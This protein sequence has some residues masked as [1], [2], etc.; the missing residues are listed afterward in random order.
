M[1]FKIKK[2]VLALLIGAAALMIFPAAGGAL[3]AAGG[4]PA[5]DR[6]AGYLL[7]QEVLPGR[8]L[9]PWSYAA[10]GGCGYDLAGTGVGQS[11]AQQFEGLQSGELNNYSLLVLTLLAAGD[12]PYDYRGQD[13]VERIRAAQLPDGKFADKVDGGGLGAGGEQVLANAH[14]WA[15]LA[16]H[17]AGA[18]VPDARKAGE[19]LC[20]RQRD[21]GSFNWNLAGRTPDVDSTGMALLALG[22]LGEKEGPVVQK[23]VA[24]LKSVQEEDGGFSSWGAANAESCCMV[25]SGLAAV[26]I[27]P[28]GADWTAPAGSPVTA[29]QSYRLPDGSY[30]HIKGAGSNVMATEQALQAL[31]DLYYG[32]TLFDRLK[33]KAPAV[34]VTGNTPQRTIRFKLETVQYEVVSD[35][36]KQLL[37]TDAAPFLE[38]DRTY[39]PVRYL[40]LALGVPEEGISWSPAAR[41]VT[42]VKDGVTVTLA[43]GGNIMYVDNR[44]V[45]MDVAPLLRPPG[46]AFLP[47]RYVAEAF[48]YE[49][50][51][52][53]KERAVIITG[54][55][56]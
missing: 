5:L 11:C 37:E 48:N 25:I 17:A 43:V 14:M 30:E 31:A 52:D 3:P 54:T 45:A 20:S 35:G 28:A 2:A 40:A 44:Q 41:T 22:A 46:R 38:N 18:G 10:L 16:L 47:A 27:D 21:D 49:V 7:E 24:Y 36:T 56:R 39:V 1:R 6:T 13:L 26:G 4:R 55:C 23:A 53:Q 50:A 51:W 19:W 32:N 9:A 34:A 8:L 12:N 29:L 15:V 42:L 33:E